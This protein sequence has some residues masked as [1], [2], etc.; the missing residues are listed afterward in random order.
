MARRMAMTHPI[1]RALP[2]RRAVGAAIGLALAGGPAR[3]AAPWQPLRPVTLVVP[4]AAGGTADT[5]ARPLAEGMAQRLGVPVVVENRPGAQTAIGAEAVA[6]GPADGHRL[7]L[8]A[9]ATLT[10]NPLLRRDLPYRAED[11]APVAHLA[12]LPYAVAV[13]DGLP[14]ALRDFIAHVRAFP[15]RVSLG[16]LGPGSSLHLAGALIAAGLGL[17][18]NEVAYRS[19]GL[20]ANDL[21]A[22]ILDAAVLG[23]PAALAAARTGRA[24]LV[25]WTAAARLPGRPEEP[26]FAEA[27]PGLV[28]TGWLGLHAP[29]ATP[30]AAIARLNAV[31]AGALRADP[32]LR[33]RLQDQGLFLAEAGPPAAFAAYLAQE[34]ER[35]AALLARIGLRP[36]P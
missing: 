16:H 11:F 10:V 2:R 31:A 32:L 24:H 5:L 4:Y 23:G 35:L 12:T 14:A 6:R 7:L 1:G 25:A 8:S 21:M 28:A 34:T 30:P 3:G 18:F 15:G 27:A 29:A 9:T 17:A 19:D 26:V 36:G 33:E 13:R 20:A 22:G